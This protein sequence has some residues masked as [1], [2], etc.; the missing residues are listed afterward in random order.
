MDFDSGVLGGGSAGYAAARTLAAG[1]RRV[2]VIDGAPELGGLCILRGCMP[3]KALLRAAELRRAFE[4]AK[5]WGVEAPTPRVD[6]AKLYG[7][8][9]ALIRDFAGYRQKQ[10]AD[11]RFELVRS[12]AR[13]VGPGTVALADGRTIS[14]R[15][16]VVATGSEVAPP[17]VPGL[18]EAGYLTSD[19]ALRLEKQPGSLIVLGGGPV[20]VEFAQFFARLGTEVTLLQR[21]GHLLRDADADVAAELE[22]GLR[23]EGVRLHTGVRILGVWSEAKGKR[24]EF[25]TPE[26]VRTVL[27]EEVFHG[28]GR[29]P[30]T[31]GLNLAAAGVE[32]KA[33]GHIRTDAGQRTSAAGVMAAGD[34]C[35]PHEIVH[36][37]IQQGE[38]AARNLLHP[39]APVELD[40]RLLLSVVFTEPQVAQAGLTEKRAA[41][42]GL[43]VR[44]A[45]YPFN[46]HGKS[47]I[48]GAEEGFVKLIVEAATGEIVGGAC[49]GPQAGE[50][51]HEVQV[52]M[53]ARMTARAF[54]AVPH[55]HPTLAEIWTYPAEEL[56]E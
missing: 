23:R 20:A 31:A 32:V 30:A 16:W 44:A 10:L 42:A 28:L 1:G 17:P 33:S 51:I 35:G 53:A 12:Q 6:W 7:H 9:D 24:L 27:A 19:D 52:A 49:V 45:T 41:A 48:L 47:I 29:R 14:A 8:K 5:R 18:A 15:E 46:D 2:V 55:Y 21:S 56:A 37:A 3:T 43:K 4:E 13:F 36:I 25:S 40:E 34:C 54:A 50:L 22:K 11:G 39:E 38:T 26:G